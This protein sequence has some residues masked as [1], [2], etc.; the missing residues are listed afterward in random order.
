MEFPKSQKGG[1]DYNWR[2]HA[3][4]AYRNGIKDARGNDWVRDNVTGTWFLDNKSRRRTFHYT[5]S[6][7]DMKFTEVGTEKPA[8]SVGSFCEVH[9][10]YSA[11]CTG[12]FWKER[13]RDDP[14]SMII[15]STGDC[16]V[17]NRDPKQLKPS[18]SS[19]LLRRK[20]I[21]QVR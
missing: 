1:P 16:S 5:G 8:A 13:P 20:K 7:L 21:D 9:T 15:M 11:P 2:S 6:G 12:G 10:M 18:F 19:P 14:R 4:T 3:T 17:S